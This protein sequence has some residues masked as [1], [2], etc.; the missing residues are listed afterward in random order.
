MRVLDQ[1]FCP[2]DIPPEDGWEATAAGAAAGAGGLAAATGA[3]GFAAATGA[4][5]AT[6]G[7]G[8]L[9]PPSSAAFR[10]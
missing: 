1:A 5:G 7:A 9:P 8:V 4:G 3:G 6:A 10:R 2:T